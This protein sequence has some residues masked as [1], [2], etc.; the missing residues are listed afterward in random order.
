MRRLAAVLPEAVRMMLDGGIFTIG[1][2]TWQIVGLLA[3]LLIM[4]MGVS[5]GIEKANK[6]MMPLLFG[7]F[8]L[9][10]VYIA[11]L[12]GSGEGYRYIFTH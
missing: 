7:L 2:S 11:F 5:G 3:A 8:L 10:G 6:I 1:N 9:L 12:P 4:A